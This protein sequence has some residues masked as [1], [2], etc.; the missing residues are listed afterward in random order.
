MDGIGSGHEEEASS[1][2]G[3]KLSASRDELSFAGLAVNECCDSG[4]LQDKRMR[5]G[6]LS[7][8]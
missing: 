1:S 8:N 2:T 5:R 6:E 7:V 4:T 3:R